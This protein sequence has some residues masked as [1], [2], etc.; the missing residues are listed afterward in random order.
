MSDL[1]HYRLE[2]GLA[3]IGLACPPVNALS[4]AMSVAISESCARAA[5]DSSVQA[6]ILY[7]EYGL[8]SAGVD[9]EQLG[10][11]AF[12]CAQDL[13]NTLLRVA[14]INKPVIAAVGRQALGSGLE[15]ALACGYRIGE[16]DTRVGLSEIHFGLLPRAGGTQRLPRLIGA[17]SA[18]NLILSGEQVDAECA[19]LLGI[20]DRLAPSFSQLL[21]AARAYAY[22]LISSGAPARPAAAWPKPAEGLPDDFLA[23]YRA[24]HEQRWKSRLAPRLAFSALEAA[25]LLPMEEGLVRE[26]DLSRQAEASRQSEALRHVFLAER[27]A[28]RV[29]GIGED[30]PL[31]KIKRVAVIGAGDMGGSIAMC[32]A[33][34][35]IPVAL[36]DLSKKALARGLMQVRKNYE[37]S[38]RR[39]KMTFEQLGQHMDLLF[40]T[41][42]YAELSEA[43]LVIESVFES[44][45][46]KAQVFR[47]LDEV[48]KPGAILATT[49]SSL[50]VDALAAT[51][52][53]PQDVIGLHFSSPANLMRLVEVVRGKVTAP[54]VLATTMQ[55]AKRLGKLPV[56]SSA[57]FGFIGNR[58]FEP[59]VREAH[60]L[61]LEGC[62]PAQVDSAFTDL[63]L[64]MGVFSMLDLVGIDVN[65][66]I[67]N[68]NRAAIG[69]DESYCRLGDELYAMGRYG[70]RFGRGFYL[71]DGRHRKNDHQVAALAER[72]AGELRIRRRSITPLEIV[73]RCLFALINEGV[74]LLDEGIALRA[75]DIDLVWVN[76]YGFP[77]HLGGPLH[78]AE[79]LGLSKVL[80]GLRHYRELLG[81]YGELWFK[82][83]PL[84][85]RL[86]AAGENRIARI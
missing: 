79:K 32:F 11:H 74:Q 26:A 3:L 80:D 29:P 76:G 62:L 53:R 39:G 78:Y 16:P 63:D 36:L 34:A 8:F 51:V 14:E 40:G 22:E 84:L 68:S 4:G 67:R 18:L 70:Q 43:D 69:H 12:Y 75:S 15:L 52:S 59:Y 66:Q 49:T 82:P 2:D 13:G 86:V 31:R 41:I 44:F 37:N 19:R 35:G 71:Y 73:E 83:A 23:R 9:I 81:E 25:C 50:D 56:V 10:A 24:R 48:C 61:V 27:E 45:E 38:V 7:G 55:T 5:N 17:E 65:H 20:L 60:R 47:T 33:N 58:M 30:V 54:D 28:A 46:T 42:D 1:I 21:D 57:C 85:E 72:L 77:A 64:E 6:I